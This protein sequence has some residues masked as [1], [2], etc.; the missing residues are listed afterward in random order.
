ME[1]KSLLLVAIGGA[2]GAVARYAISEWI[3]SEFPWGTLL[4]NILGS[5]LLGVLVSAG[6]AN[7]HVTP[8][9]LLLIYY[10]VDLQSRFDST[11]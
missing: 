2:C 1:P 10:N 6:I 5:F 4:V 7:E 8:E 9:M 3:P 11:C